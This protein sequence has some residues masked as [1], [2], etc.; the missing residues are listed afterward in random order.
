MLLFIPD[1]EYNMYVKSVLEILEFN[2]NYT[3]LN[4]LIIFLSFFHSKQTMRDQLL[5]IAFY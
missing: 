3:S 1:L 2:P 4:F 5:N